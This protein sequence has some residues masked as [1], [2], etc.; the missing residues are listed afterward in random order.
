MKK[1]PTK[2]R[3]L[4][5][6]QR[7]FVKALFKGET[8]AEAA[9]ESGYKGEYPKQAG[10]QALKTIR[11]R[12]PEVLEKLGLGPEPVI[13]KYLLPALDA[14]ETQFFSWKGDVCDEREVI[15][16]GPRIQA[17]ELWA[18]LAGAIQ[19]GKI[20]VS[21]EVKHGIDLSGMPDEFLF[22]LV[23]LAQKR[24]VSGEQGESGVV[25][26]VSAPLAVG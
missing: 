2:R 4:K 1:A 23:A 24:P 17:M 26:E 11:A 5:K 15:A 19:N 10:Y 6:N 25:P 22:G 12:M 7:K 21:G 18:R 8:L 9:I 13:T 20:D 14:K 16:W 3:A